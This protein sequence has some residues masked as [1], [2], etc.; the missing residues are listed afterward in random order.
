M[1]AAMTTSDALMTADELITTEEFT[2]GACPECHSEGQFLNIGRNHWGVC[3]EHRTRW[4]IGENLFSAWRDE[5]ESTWAANR[6]RIKD[7]R[8]VDPYFGAEVPVD[9]VRGRR[10][11]VLADALALYYADPRSDAAAA[12]GVAHQLGLLDQ[13]AKAI[14]KLQRRRDEQAEQDRRDRDGFD[15]RLAELLAHHRALP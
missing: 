12:V 10:D 6:E 4:W 14:A 9:F 1:G 3:H 5:D 8:D 11:E 2:F 15:S 13:F 7:Y